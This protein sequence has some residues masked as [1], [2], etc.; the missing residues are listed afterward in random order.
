MEKRG[1]FIGR[2]GEC[3]ECA[4]NIDLEKLKNYL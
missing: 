3:S 4:L 1:I 2:K